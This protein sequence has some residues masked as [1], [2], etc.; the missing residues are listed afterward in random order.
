MDETNRD[1]A[2]VYDIF[3]ELGITEYKKYEHKAFFSAADAD[4]EFFTLPGLNLKNL[5]VKNKKA[6]NYYMVILED[7]V[8][9]DVKHFKEV[10]GWGKIRF[11][12]DEEMWQLL[13]LTPGSVTPFALFN[14]TEK[15]I[16]VVIGRDLGDAPDDE[17]VNFHPCRN[18]ATI[19]LKK[20][21]FMK[22]LEHMG[23]DVIFE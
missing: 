7:N 11:A 15:Q 6:G 19:A 12:N 20:K 3:D 1:E 13:K 9:M 17:L 5:L 8:R 21:D 10:T 2:R 18:T 16:T 22:Y 4:E 14:D 23:N